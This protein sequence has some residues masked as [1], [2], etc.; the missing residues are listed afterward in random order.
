[1]KTFKI[2]NNT[3]ITFGTMDRIRILFGKEVKV[4]TTIHAEKEVEVFGKMTE[5]HVYVEPFIKP[6]PITLE[7]PKYTM[8]DFEDTVR[9]NLDE[10]KK[11]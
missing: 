6:K 9:D 10:F 3:R 2:F 11:M 1:M 8:K 7:A 4:S 5:H